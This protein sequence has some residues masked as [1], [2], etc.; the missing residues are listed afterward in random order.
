MFKIFSQLIQNQLSNLFQGKLGA[1]K[2][3]DDYKKIYNGMGFR[4]RYFIEE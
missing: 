1:L 4:D 2:T 3:L